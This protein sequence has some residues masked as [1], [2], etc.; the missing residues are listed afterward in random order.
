MESEGLFK[1]SVFGGFDKQAVLSYVDDLIAQQQKKDAELKSRAN[2][3]EMERDQFA[4]KVGE[5]EERLREAEERAKTA[6]A[7]QEDLKEKDAR[8]HL[9]EQELEEQRTRADA[10]EKELAETSER[11]RKYD[12]FIAQVGLVMVEAQNQADAIVSRA[13]TQAED[14]ARESMDRIYGLC[15]QVDEVDASVGQLRSFAARTM[16]EVDRRVA[17]LEEAVR[18]TQGHLY[19]SAGVT[20]RDQQPPEEALPEPAPQEADSDFFGSAGSRQT[21]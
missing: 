5:L 20:A 2:A 9:L 8:L 6:E 10:L 21:D 19:I 1:T 12:G 18:E 15:R 11:T 7:S 4:S 3:L 13:R 17:D 16:E 14:I